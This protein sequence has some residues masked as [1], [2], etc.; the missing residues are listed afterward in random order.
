M[1][2][3]RETRL[4]SAQLAVH[5]FQIRCVSNNHRS[6]AVPIRLGFR[7]EGRLRDDALID[8][9]LRDRELYALLA[10][11]WHTTNP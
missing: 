11:D 1:T 3:R 8:G 10:P 9:V 7:H 5:R 4:H 6:R 2:G